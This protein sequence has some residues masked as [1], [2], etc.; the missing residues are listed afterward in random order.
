MIQND[1]T[2]LV[3][4]FLKQNEEFESKKK[5]VQYL[6]DQNISQVILNKDAKKIK[7]IDAKIKTPIENLKYIV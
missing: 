2:N 7:F 3:E 5:A 6:V 1:R 4:S